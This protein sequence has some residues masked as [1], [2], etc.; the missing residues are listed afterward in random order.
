MTAQPQTEQFLS[1][2]QKSAGRLFVHSGTIGQLLDEARARGTMRVFEDLVFLSK[3]LSKTYDLLRRIGPDG[4]GFV[5][6]SAEF[7]SN[8][9]KANTLVKTLVKESADPVKQKIV[10]TFLRLDQESMTAFM[11]L[12]RE[13]AW[14]KNWMVDGK[15]LPWDK[16]AP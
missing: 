9:E 10:G 12:L 8:L 14:V 5:K 11:E 2:L 16:K 13:L 3:F 6:I 7:Q 1:D 4:E 15:P